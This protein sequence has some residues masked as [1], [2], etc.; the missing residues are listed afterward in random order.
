MHSLWQL[1]CRLCKQQLAGACTF[2]AAV[3]QQV[4]KAAQLSQLKFTGM[5]A[6]LHNVAHHFVDVSPATGTCA[7]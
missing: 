3:D 5:V 7:R 4:L 1:L 6:M 2:L